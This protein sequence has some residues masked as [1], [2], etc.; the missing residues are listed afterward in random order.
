MAS[1]ATG[2]L[3]F[4]KLEDGNVEVGDRGVEPLGTQLE[5]G[6]EALKSEARSLRS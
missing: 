6:N 2:A 3:P 4:A 5:G 1:T